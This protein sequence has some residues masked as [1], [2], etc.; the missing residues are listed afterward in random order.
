MLHSGQTAACVVTDSPRALIELSDERDR[1]ERLVLASWLDG[2][3]AC[4]NQ[5]ADQIGGRIMPAHPTPLALVRWHV[6]CARCRRVG[7]RAGCADC[8]DRTRATF[9]RPHPDD[10][11]GRAA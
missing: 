9:G 4:L 10:F 1:W 5:L 11:E 6:C 8:Q 7:H 3:T 2:Y